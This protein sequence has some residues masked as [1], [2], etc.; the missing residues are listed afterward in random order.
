M[1]VIAGKAR[2]IQLKSL[3][4]DKTRPT[5]DR[6]KETLFNTIQTYIPDSYFIDVFAGTGSIGIEAL[7]RGAA[8]AVFIENNKKAVAVINENLEKTRLAENAE[9]I[10]SDAISALMR[11][12]HTGPADVI[13]IDPPYNRGYEIQVLK[14]LGNSKLVGEDTLIIAEISNETELDELTETGFEIV[15]TKDYRTNRHVLMIPSKKS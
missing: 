11:I 6:Y 3:E 15:K 9:V 12:E 4:G 5:L 14:L 13:F 8:K 7:S 1:R 10:A 2:R